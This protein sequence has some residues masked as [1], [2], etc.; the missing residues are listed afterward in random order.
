MAKKYIT[1]QKGHTPTKLTQSAFRGIGWSI[2]RNVETSESQ[3][4]EFIR[5]VIAILE[6][7]I[8]V[9]SPEVPF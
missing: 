9:F 1:A 3:R 8:I 6:G 2:Q 5:L 7:D 4:K